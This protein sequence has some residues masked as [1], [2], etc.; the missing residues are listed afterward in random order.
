MRLIDTA[1]IEGAF[2]TVSGDEVVDIVNPAN[3]KPIGRQRL[4]SRQDAQ[5]AIA[6]ASHA[7]TGGTLAQHDGRAARHAAEPPG[8]HPSPRRRDP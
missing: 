8:R 7:R 3:E 1:Y 4:A 6:A 5:R 2:I